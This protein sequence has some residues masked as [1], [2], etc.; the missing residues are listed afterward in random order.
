LVVFEGDY[1]L[2]K[3]WFAFPTIC[4]EDS[5]GTSKE[6]LVDLLPLAAPY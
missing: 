3:A 1:L 5:A 4:V 2:G 6:T